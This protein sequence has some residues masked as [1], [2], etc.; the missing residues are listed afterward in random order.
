M[1]IKNQKVA[2]YLVIILFI[3]SCKSLSYSPLP[4]DYKTSKSIEGIYYNDPCKNPFGDSKLWDFIHY[5][6]SLEKDSLCVSLKLI[7]EKR[8]YAKLLNGDSV[9]AEKEMKIEL[10]EDG[11]YY[12]KRKSYIV[13]ILPILWFYSNSQK[14]FIVGKK[15]VIVERTSSDGGAFI[16]MAG[17]SENNDSW[18]YLKKQ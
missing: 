14:R 2:I 7:D 16:I 13:P 8:L 1:A 9:V 18:E 15:S 10:K 5:K 4:Y 17:G 3:S 6:S 11:C 12:T